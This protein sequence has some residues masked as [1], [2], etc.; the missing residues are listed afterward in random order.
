MMASR[1]FFLCARH[2]SRSLIAA[3][4]LA[5]QASHQWDIWCSPTQDT[6]GLELAEQVLSE[7]NIPLIALVHHIEP[8]FGMKW[9]EGIVLCSGMTDV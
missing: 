8:T 5:A 3:S 7:R 6:H 2:S 9:D 1:I 4:L